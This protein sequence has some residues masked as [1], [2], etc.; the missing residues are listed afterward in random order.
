VRL[1][2][3]GKLKNPMTSL[4]KQT[5]IVGVGRHQQAMTDIDGSVSEIRFRV[6]PF[7]GKRKKK[8]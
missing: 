4:S 7:R 1:E 5:K 2:G 3:L 6:L 8:K